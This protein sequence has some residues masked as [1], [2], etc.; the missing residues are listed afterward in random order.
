M[1]I[2]KPVFRSEVI[3]SRLLG[4]VFHMYFP[5]LP[6]FSLVPPHGPLSEDSESDSHSKNGQAWLVPHLER[7]SDAHCVAL[8]A[9]EL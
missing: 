6:S 9:T 3:A 4:V 8:A 5:C 2:W 7:E 1:D